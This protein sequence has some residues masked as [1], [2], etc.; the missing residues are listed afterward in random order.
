M[1]TSSPSRPAYF[2][3]YQDEDC[4]EL[5]LV[6]VKKIF[7]SLIKREA[8]SVST[9]KPTIRDMTTSI[10]LDNRKPT[11]LPSSLLPPQVSLCVLSRA[12][13]PRWRA[14]R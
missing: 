2:N 13:V 3:R 10:S 11:S 8:L 9:Y 4:S 7:L 5:Q 1:F 14:L 6:H 12:R